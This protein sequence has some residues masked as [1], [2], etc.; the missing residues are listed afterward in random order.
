MPGQLELLNNDKLS[1]LHVTSDIP[2]TN[3]LSS[4]IACVVRSDI[5]GN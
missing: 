1:A 3:S 2:L 5:R 4:Q